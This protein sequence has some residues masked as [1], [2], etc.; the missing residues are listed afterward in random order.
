MIGFF[1]LYSVTA[2]VVKEAGGWRAF[3]IWRRWN[4]YYAGLMAKAAEQCGWSPGEP[5][6][7]VVWQALSAVYFHYRKF[8]KEPPGEAP[9]AMA[10]LLSVLRWALEHICERELAEAAEK[11]VQ[12]LK[13]P[14]Y[15]AYRQALYRRYLAPLVRTHKVESVLSVGGGLVEPYDLLEVADRENIHFELYV[16][17]VDKR[18]AEALA[19]EG[20]YVYLGD[21][22][23]L[24][25]DGTFGKTSFDFATVQAV[26]H[27]TEDPVQLLADV[28][29]IA[30]YVLVSQG[31]GPHNAAIMVA[32]MLMGAKRFIASPAEID[33][34]VKSAGL[35]PVKPVI[36]SSGMY[37]G[38][39]RST[40]FK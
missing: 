26:L 36:R 32:T 12:M 5:S 33:A 2:P 18:V 17:E 11:Y 35:A 4:L 20:F 10:P 22:R 25:V 13:A 29:K 40:L 15:R 9:P 19:E 31:Y 30:K 16:Q 1:R 6:D 3:S 28:A 37:I 23:Q 8:P 14:L 38:L 24:L 39:F 7:D 21:V 34:W 27:W